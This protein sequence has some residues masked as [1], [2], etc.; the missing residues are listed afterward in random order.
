VLAAKN[1]QIKTDLE[2]FFS[3]NKKQ[4]RE[5]RVLLSELWESRV[6]AVGIVGTYS[7][8]LW[9]PIFFVGIVG[10]YFFRRNC[11]KITFFF[12]SNF[13]VEILGVMKSFSVIQHFY[14]LVICLWQKN[15]LSSS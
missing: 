11:G 6:F 2:I 7:L 1:G 3:N 15:E 8:E 12:F 9:E 13:A 4:C 10:T 5:N 14:L